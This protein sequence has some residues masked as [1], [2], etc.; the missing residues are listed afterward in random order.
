[1]TVFD[2]EGDG[3]H[4]TKFHV[5]SYASSE[6][7]QSITCQKAM[8]E[9]LEAQDVL[10]G[11]N[12]ALWDVPHLERVLGIKIKAKLID[13]LWLSWYLTP[14]RIRHGLEW[15]GKDFGVHKPVVTDWDNLPLEDYVHRCEEDVK[16]NSLLWDKQQALLADL[17]E[18]DQPAS[19]PIISYL[20]FKADC[21]REQERSRW[22]LDVEFCQIAY[23]KLLSEQEPRI[24]ALKKVMPVVIKQVVKHPPNKPFKKDGTL[25]VEGAK[26]QKYLLDQGL[27]TKHNQPIYVVVGEEEANPNSPEQLKNW[28]FNL[29]WEPETFKFVKE[30]SGQER[31]IPQIKLPNSPDLC[32]SVL[33]LAE[34]YPSVLELEKLSVVKHRL[35]LLAGFLSNKDDEGFLK[36]RVQGLTNTL[37]LK[38]SEIVNLPGIDK[39]YGS[40]IRGCLVAREGHQLVGTDMVSL[41]DNTKRHFMYFHD[42]TYVDEM[43]D[44]L[45]DPHLD[46]A[47]RA[48]VVDKEDVLIYKK[49][50]ESNDNGANILSLIKTITTLRKSY[51][52]V[53]Y[54][55]VYGVGATKLAR[56]LKCSVTSAKK[57]LEQY[58]E[59]NWA[60]KKVAEDCVIKWCD[61]RMWLYNPVSKF[62]YSLRNEKDKFST[63][64]QGTGVYCFDSWVKEC[65]KRRPQMTGQFHDETVSEVKIGFAEKLASLQQDAIDAVNNRLKL[66]IKLAIDTHTGFRYSD[67]H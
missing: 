67:I 44:P 27:T 7:P 41:E 38:H 5:L 58:W 18:T 54:S 59:R 56:S 3:L 65:R 12:I 4:P 28:L 31:K 29:G 19:L 34:E 15:W 64:N 48:G 51:K 8:G 66:N 61:K 57:M 9:W 60:V 24:E 49:F 53:N 6:G 11:H 52:V 20:M 43:S 46:L 63:L 36:A 40:D 10:C 32:G 47:V 26:W 2:C 45:F 55:S 42:P 14:D 21:A 50:K 25:S 23:D 13:T 17:Y 35:G 30:D 62:W 33:A 16:I 1:M 37:R 22:K 39:P